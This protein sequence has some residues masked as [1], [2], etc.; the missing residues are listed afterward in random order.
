MTLEQRVEKAI[1]FFGE[2]TTE[3]AQLAGGKG[4]TLAKLYKAGYP[5]PEGLVILPTSFD[6]DEL[7]PEA[8]ERV[9]AGLARL[10]WGKEKTVF[11]VRSSALSEDSLQASFAGEFETVLDVSSDEKVREAIRVVRRSRG[12]ERIKTYSQAKGLEGDHDMAVVVQRLVPA[13]ISGVLFTADPVSGG[14]KSMTGQYV[15]G[16]GDRLVAG[17]VTGSSFTIQRPEGRYQGPNELK[18]YARKLAKLA[19]RL[20]RDLGCPQD[21]E[22]AIAGKE[23]Y[24]LQSRPITTLQGYDPTKGEWNA[25]LTGDYLW[26]NVNFGE[27]VSAVMTPLSWTVLTLILEA[28]TF[29]PG[30]P[31]VGSIAGRPYL[32]I[33]LFA[34]VLHAQGKSEKAI[35]EALEGMVYTR[36]PQGMEIPRLPLSRW[37]V[38]TNF[39]DLIRMQMRQRR[40]VKD[41]PTYL[42]KNPDW[43][44][45]MQTQIQA[46]ATKPELVSLWFEE[47]KPH[48]TESVWGV[49]GSATYSSDYTIPLRR[50]LTEL[51]GPDDAYVLIANLSKS[52][53]LLASLGPLVGLTQV[54]QGQMNRTAY[55]EQYGHRGPHEFELSVPRPAEDPAWLD[56]Q[57]EQLGDAPDDVGALLA[58]GRA[59]FETT[60]GRFVAR[61]PRQAKSMRRRLKE[62]GSRARL[63]EA[64]RS[65]Y[66]RDRWI[67]RIF[68]LRAGELS[69]LGEDIFFLTFNEVLDLLDGD[70][71]AVKYIPARRETYQKYKALPT[72]PP[73]IRGRFDPFQWVADPHRR[74]DFFDSHSPLPSIS[75]SKGDALVITG[76]PGA[77]GRVEGRVRLL[78]DP[79]EGKQLLKGEVLVTT[80]TDIAWT[81][82]F[83]RATAIVT[84]VGA[85]LSHAAI[86]ARELGI[87]SV[88][89]CADATM[90]L[91]TG[92]KV[93]I[94]GGQGT[95]EILEYA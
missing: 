58:K 66:V 13:S 74:G 11:A 30:Y 18:P 55:L 86:I 76:S 32:N 49:L 19:T 62:V 69:G 47:I 71:D 72:C 5:V 84:D 73:V 6:G 38:L 50:K 28:W 92:D 31:A 87:P 51:M 48:V 61:Y 56:R 45:L 80:Q 64:A 20:E 15:H 1:Q 42:A 2:L 94:D 17:Q 4:A 88:V 89:G 44:K 12:S 46:T 63:R 36:L 7:S 68:A 82:L 25:S 59:E 93:R 81:P 65:E 83:P 41:L 23:I 39:P 85:P 8:W 9:Q 33:S 16:Q 78:E 27:A 34:T 91:K 3:Y 14:R 90:R 35:L 26:S 77:V 95:V 22:W 21:I 70:E 29:I 10:R 37:S 53:D 60:W 79:E 57:L 52:S 75:A 43:C 67:M 54:A 24:L 40:A